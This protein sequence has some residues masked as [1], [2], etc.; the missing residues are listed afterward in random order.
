MNSGELVD[1]LKRRNIKRVCYFHTDHF[2]PWSKGVNENTAHGVERFAKLSRES[3][4]AARMSLFYHTHLPYRLDQNVI[5]SHEIGVD[6]VVFGQRSTLQSNLIQQVMTPLEEGGN[7]EIHI[8]VHHES[9]T[10]N[11]GEYSK[12]VSK[13]VNENS[14]E[15]MDRA[16]F[17][18]ALTQTKEFIAHDIS[19]PIT[20][21]AFV[22]G[23]WALNGSDRSICWIDDEIQI[24]MRHGCFGDFTFPAGRRHCDPT[25]LNEPYTCLPVNKPK[26]YDLA[27][28]KPLTMLRG[29][30]S[31]QQERFF[32]WNSEIKADFSSLDYY[33]EPNRETF[34][35]PENVVK[36][37]LEKSVVIGQILFIKTH[38]HSMKWE[39]EIE[40]DINPIPHLYPDTIQIFKLLEAVCES[41]GVEI[42]VLAVSDVMNML[43]EFVG[44][45]SNHNM[46]DFTQTSYV[47][48]KQA[49]R[50]IQSFDSNFEHLKERKTMGY[51]SKLSGTVLSEHCPI[52]NS[53]NTE[54]I[55]KI[56]MTNIDPPAVLFGGY[57]NQVPTLK[58]PFTVYC[59]DLCKE[60][61]SI[62]LNP[63]IPRES[64]IES[65]KKSTHYIS[66]MENKDEW[67]GYVE[68]Y[69]MISKYVKKG[70]TSMIDAASGLGQIAFLA[71]DDKNIKWTKIVALELS[72]AY[73]KNMNENGI[74]AY[75]FDIDYHP[76]ERY[77]EPNSIDFAVFFE[78]FEHVERPTDALKKLL[79]ALKPGGRLFFSAQR[80]GSDVNLAVRPGEPI[81]I[82]EKY[83]HSIEERL[84][85]KLVDVI[86]SGSRYF[87]V[88]EKTQL[89]DEIAEI[90]FEREIQ[91]KGEFTRETGNCW[92]ADLRK[93]CPREFEYLSVIAD[94]DSTPKRSKLKLLEKNG[95]ALTELGASHA[96]HAHI[97]SVG[98]GKFSHW[99]E[100]LYFSTSDNTDPNTNGKTYFIVV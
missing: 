69:E 90:P 46:I 73:V 97:R 50:T 5:T 94:R 20:R 71:R 36:N 37:W 65:Y 13:W 91:L 17:N 44:S 59:F 28:S 48:A 60:C 87:V 52:C 88:V 55:W 92:I 2:E 39:Y 49:T 89:S 86:G 82:G 63:V 32:I 41:A 51:S 18:R 30:A 76:M 38:A 98:G 25:I 61:E 35:N 57:F 34:K 68:R 54:N 3:R 1:I 19:R 66:K 33:S 96:L 31:F 14:D 4:F 79:W 70:D 40:K 85:C 12:D 67:R 99:K 47:D 78:A 10:R 62:F 56:P 29:N 21:W 64:I 81:Y 7:H 77:F 8:H 26:G 80:Y 43:Q 95:N 11:T 72:S 45:E 53:K 15:E 24:L 16:R 75:E 27:A 100:E 42:E 93:Q 83:I 58:S 9:W 84:N 22:H 74:E 6:A 23:N